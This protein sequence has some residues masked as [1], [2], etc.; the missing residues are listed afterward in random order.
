M[1]NIS[2]KYHPIFIRHSFHLKTTGGVLRRRAGE[3]QATFTTVT[4]L[5]RAVCR[6]K[7]L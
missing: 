7:G 1:D 2:N 5:K 4:F 6:R 3:G